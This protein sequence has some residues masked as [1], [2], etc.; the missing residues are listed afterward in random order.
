MEMYMAPA[1]LPVG[2]FFQETCASDF[3]SGFEMITQ[4]TLKRPNLQVFGEWLWEIKYCMY[5]ISRA[6][7]TNQNLDSAE[8]EVEV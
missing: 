7:F 6:L 1:L 2:Y 5:M 4:G 8:K 3:H